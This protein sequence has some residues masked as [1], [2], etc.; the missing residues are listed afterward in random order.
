MNSQNLQLKGTPVEQILTEMKVRKAR[1]NLL[2]FTRFTMPEYRG[3]WHHELICKKLDEFIEG[4]NKRLIIACPPRHGKTE[5]ASRRFPAYLLG[6]NPDCKIIACSYAADLA[7]LINRDVQRIIGSPEYSVLFPETRLNASNVRTTSQENYLRNSDI[8]EIVGRKGVYRSAGV[9][10]SITGMGGNCLIVDDPFRSRADAE[11]PT[12]RNKVYEWYTST[13]RTRRQKDASILLIAT[14]WHEDDLTGRLLELAKNNPDAD[15]WEVINL[16]ALSEEPL[17]EYDE[18]TGP[19]QALWPD[20]F[21]EVDLL[22]TKASS[23]VYEWLSLYQQ[24]PSAAAGN[25]ISYDQFKYCKLDTSLCN[26]SSLGQALLILEENKKYTLSQCRI[27][28]T[29]DPAASE[30]E[31]A[32]YFALGTWAQTP[33]NDI[34][35]IDLIH[36]RMEKPKQLPFMRSQFIKWNPVTQWV[37]TKGLGIS[38]FQDLRNE[39]LPVQKIEE[40]SDKFTRFITACNRIATGSVYFLDTLPYKAEYEA[41]LLEFPNGKHDDLVDITSM[42]AYVIIRYPYKI[43]G[44]YR[45]NYVSASVSTGGLRI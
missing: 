29:C 40:E 33:N 28:Q 11:S 2:D 14:R 10:G 43:Q 30:K 7:S 27:F 39:G 25:L 41:E 6:R 45:T 42:A 24:R 38:L 17:E 5:L 26:P 34:A 12:I 16:P 31:S 36:V 22:S 23:T 13:F 9:G 1:S 4:K 35:L 18:R 21:P 3:S 20:E 19:G 8:F 44:S 32:D 37:A 15:Q